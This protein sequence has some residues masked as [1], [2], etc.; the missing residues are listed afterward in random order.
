MKRYKVYVY[1]TEYQFHDWYEENAEDPVDAKN[2]AVQ[3]LAD[4]TGTGLNE[5]EVTGVKKVDEND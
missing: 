5:Y 1:D 4:E 2:T 3:R